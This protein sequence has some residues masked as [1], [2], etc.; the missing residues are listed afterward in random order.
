MAQH[1]AP[2]PQLIPPLLWRAPAFIWTPIALVLA[3]GWPATLMGGDEGATRGVMIAGGV[4]FALALT[5]LAVGWAGKRPPRTY[6]TVIMH[7]LAA[8][9]LVALV[10]PFV[11]VGM[12]EFSAASRTPEQDSVQLPLSASLTMIPLTLLI[13][14]PTALFSGIVFALVAFVKAQRDETSGR[15]DVQPFR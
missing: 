9:L 14:L 6:R 5:S 10:A 12:I 4:T 3:I 11:L 2:V 8:G 15:N 7:V 1:R 13:G